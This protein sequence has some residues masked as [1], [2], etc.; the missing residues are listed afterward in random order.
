MKLNIGSADRV[1]RI[2][3]GLVLVGLTIT[4]YIGVWGWLGL[5]LLATALINW[6]PLYAVLG[7][8]TS[9]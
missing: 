3:A 4:N 9:K 2:V 7:L 8:K 6:C 5:V 1:L